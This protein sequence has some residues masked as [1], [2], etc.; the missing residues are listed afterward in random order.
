MARL[1]LLRHGQSVWNAQSKW[2]GLADPPLSPLG[3][4]QA[5]A[6]AEWLEGYGFTGTVASALERAWRTAEII[7]S[8]LGLPAPVREPGLNERDVGEWSGRSH[9]EIIRLW[10][11]MLEAWR[12]GHLDRPPG[13]EGR[14]EF[15]ERVMGVVR[16]LAA[17]EGTLLVV[18]HGGVIHAVGRGLKA[19]WRGNPNLCGWW[20]EEGLVPGDRAQPPEITSA[21][22]TIL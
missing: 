9:E 10:P 7:G 14:A 20:V 2:Q 3:V 6:A 19:E 8:K 22:T 18:C 13:G 17:Q 21:A 1:L 11:G 16:R 5:E 15:A 4:A 12:D